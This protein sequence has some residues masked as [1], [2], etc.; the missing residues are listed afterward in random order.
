MKLSIS[1]TRQETL[2]GW[3]YLL[4]SNLV[5]PTLIVQI[6]KWLALP[7]SE[8]MLNIVY[9][10]INF[11]F[12]LVIFW[13][14]LLDSFKKLLSTPW[15][16][17]RYAALGFLIYYGLTLL[18]SHIILWISPSFFNVNDAAIG[19]LSQENYSLM[20]FCVIFL[21]PVAEEVFYRGLL[22]QGLQ[23]KNRGLAYLVSVFIFAAVHVFSYIG[24]YDWLT[25]LLCFVQYLP[26]G[27]AMAWAYEKS[28]T[29]FAPILIHITINQIGMSAMR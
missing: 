21:V 23:H 9:A 28:D 3:I 6:C 5:L 25:L 4:V 2:L 20:A 22:F 15:H 29:I 1:M 7:L 16:S 11:V 10:I 24:M 27:L 8:A 18:L 26:A 19:E 13:R 12:V 17:L 14:F